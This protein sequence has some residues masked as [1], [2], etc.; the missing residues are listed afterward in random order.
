MS[1]S[2]TEGKRFFLT[3]QV[4]N[5]M[6]DLNRLASVPGSISLLYGPRGA[7]KSRLIRQF[8]KI[9]LATCTNQV[10]QFQLAGIAHALL[11]SVGRLVCNSFGW[12]AA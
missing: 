5:I 12:K 2:T 6:E 11:M 4:A 8:H 1:I 7:G 10:L 3:R 9:R